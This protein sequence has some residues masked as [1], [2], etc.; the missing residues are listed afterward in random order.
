M[1]ALYHGGKTD[2]E[3]SRELQIDRRTVAKWRQKNDYP[4][5][6]YISPKRQIYVCYLEDDTLVCEGDA[7]HCTKCL[8]Y[9]SVSVFYVMY[10]RFM[11]NG[12]GKYHIYV[13]EVPNV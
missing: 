6:P 10:A 7:E 5:N 2:T 8:G 13:R 3:I 1:H 4:T 12:G 9:K 11:R